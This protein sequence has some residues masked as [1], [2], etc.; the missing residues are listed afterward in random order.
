[1]QINE[2]LGARAFTLNYD[3]SSLEFITKSGTSIQYG[4]R[5]LKRVVNRFL[6]NP[7]AD[8]FIDG[9]ITPASEVYCKM[10]EDTTK[11]EWEVESP[12]PFDD[13]G[14]DEPTSIASMVVEQ[15]QVKRT[16]R[17]NN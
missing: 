13:S 10:N 7:L 11:I 14:N 17:K 8:D 15:P 9:R 16:R 2:R 1:V 6:L 4:A 3:E 12:G 5:E